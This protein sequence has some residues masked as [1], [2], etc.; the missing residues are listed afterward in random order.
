MPDNVLPVAHPDSRLPN[1]TD[2]PES[3]DPV[4]DRCGPSR[5]TGGP[6]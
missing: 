3:S 6:A 5:D 2:I 1:S 4:A